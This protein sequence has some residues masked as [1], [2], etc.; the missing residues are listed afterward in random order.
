MEE[1]LAILYLVGVIILGVWL[2]QTE[3]RIEKNTHATATAVQQL[4]TQPS[5]RVR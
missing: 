1:T 3:D 4:Q 2:I 5:Q